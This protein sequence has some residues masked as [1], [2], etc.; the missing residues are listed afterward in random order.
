MPFSRLDG[1][2]AQQE[3]DRPQV[4][5]V[6]KQFHGEGIA[7]AVRVPVLDACQPQQRSYCPAGTTNRAVQVGLTGPEEILGLDGNRFQGCKSFLRQLGVEWHPSFHNTNEQLPSREVHGAA[8]ELDGIGD[9]EAAVEQHQDK[10]FSTLPG[11]FEFSSDGVVDSAT[12][13]EDC[14]YFPALKGQGGHIVYP[15]GLQFFGVVLR[16][17]FS[18][19]GELQE[20]PNN[21]EFFG[22]APRGSLRA[23]GTEGPEAV[24][25]DAADLARE[26]LSQRVQRDYVAAESGLSKSARAAIL[27]VGSDSIRDDRRHI[28][29][30]G[31]FA[32][33]L[34]AEAVLRVLP[35]PGLHG[36]AHPPAPSIR[37]VDPHGALAFDV[38]DA[39]LVVAA[40]FFVSSVQSK[41][42]GIL[43]QN[44]Y[45]F[46]YKGA[47]FLENAENNHK[48]PMWRVAKTLDWATKLQQVNENPTT[49]ATENSTQMGSAV[50]GGTNFLNAPC[51]GAA[52]MAKKAAQRKLENAKIEPWPTDAQR[53]G[54]S[55]VL[56][57]RWVETNHPRPGL[58][59]V[60]G[61][62][63]DRVLH[64]DHCHVSGKFRGWLCYRCNSTLGMA[65]DSIPRLRALI[66]Y[67]E[68]AA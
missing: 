27:D 59:E 42:V 55:G 12:G 20:C 13:V 10:G 36:V 53:E 24:Q 51:S 47:R 15:R 1:C 28:G 5:S 61:I 34:G 23:E 9:P 62:P 66:A 46:G 32:P 14:I 43:S 21:V 39:L 26:V 50:R 29:G 2:V 67:L 65:Q 40:D 33:L 35:A 22:R 56:L 48:I 68:A 11:A 52:A 37:T 64:F 3:L 6:L 18:V 41:H 7:E 60:C 8:L 16:Q 57:R 30:L 45:I 49:G 4:S 31:A 54:R 38:T 19:N 58:C 17:P 63:S 25:G 44:G